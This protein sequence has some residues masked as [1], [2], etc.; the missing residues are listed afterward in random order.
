M[1]DLERFFSGLEKKIKPLSKKENYM[2]YIKAVKE[3]SEKIREA[4][5][6]YLMVRRTRTEIEKYF[7]EDLS[8]QNVKF[9]EVKDPK[10]V[11]YQFNQ[12]ENEIFHQT[13]RLIGQKLKY[14]RYMPLTYYK[15]QEQLE[16]AGMQSQK[17]LGRFMKI[18]LVKR[19]ESS[20][21]A[22]RNSIDRV[23]QSYELF[24]KEFK[25]G[26]VYVSKD[27]SNKIFD[28]LNNDDEEAVQKLIDSDKA[29]KYP[30][31]DFYREL[32]ERFDTRSSNFARDKVSLDRDPSRSQTVGLYRYS[33]L[34]GKRAAVFQ[35]SH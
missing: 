33:V 13:I 9:P 31:K 6:K 25:S 3:N 19:L 30:A 23:V 15:K 1:P 29:K 32:R 12:R 27:Y 26:N 35:I 2:E 14:S 24:L 10:P 20:F 21:F 17:N 28:L 18:L 16:L 11:Y 7:S 4:V 5:L 34:F 22:F 8:S